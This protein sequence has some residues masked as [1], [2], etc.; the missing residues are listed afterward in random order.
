MDLSII[1]VNYNTANETI[2]AIDSVLKTVTCKL[3]YEIIL[4]DNDSEESDFNTI[5]KKF[6]KEIKNM[7][8]IVLRNNS[9]QG[10][11]KANNKGLEIARGRYFLLLNSDTIVKKDVLENSVKYMDLNPIVGAVTCKLIDKEG[12]LDHGCK[13]GNPTLLASVFY[14]TKITMLFPKNRVIS[15]YKAGWLDEN[16]LG[17]VEVISGAY[18]F[19]RSDLIEKVGLL[20][21]TFFMYGEDIDFCIRILNRGYK[22]IYNPELGEVIHLKGIS[23]K[24]R[25]KETRE[26]FYDSMLIY[27]NKYYNDSFWGIRI[28]AKAGIR[29]LKEFKG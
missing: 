5:V 6:S 16:S 26:A 20:D 4:V 23:G 7:K 9:N 24:K 28:V 18:L 29:L 17:E 13:R 1:I 14:Y 2:D 21:E 8:L 12:N 19:F 3:N 15:R 10:F 25:K 11:A 22:I 27:Y